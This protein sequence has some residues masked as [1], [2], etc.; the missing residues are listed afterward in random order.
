MFTIVFL[1]CNSITGT[2]YTMAPSDVFPTID[3]C[4]RYAIGFID[5]NASLQQ[6]GKAIREDLSFQCVGWGEPV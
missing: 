3:L 1:A 4:Q 6:E 2:C 5:Y